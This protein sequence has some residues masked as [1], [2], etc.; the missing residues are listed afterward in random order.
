MLAEHLAVVSFDKPLFRGNIILQELSEIS[1]SYKTDARAVLFRRRRQAVFLRDP[2]HLPLFQP[3]ERKEHVF[4]LTLAQL[5]EEISLILIP[6]FRFEKIMRFSLVA[7]TAVMP[8]GDKV[9]AKTFRIPFE[10]PEFYLAVAQHVGIGRPPRV[11]FPEKIR[12]H[13]V[14]IFF[15]KIY[16]VIRNTQQVCDAANVRI[17]LLRGAAA[18]FVCFLPVLHKQADD[19]ETLFFQ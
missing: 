18:V 10:R 15:G 14:H 19:V 2:A 1:F 4:E 8:R 9:R 6:V 17:V 7:Y 5:V 13:S 16:R 12:K 3:A 11:I